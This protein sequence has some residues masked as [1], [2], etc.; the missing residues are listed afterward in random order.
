MLGRVESRRRIIEPAQH[1]ERDCDHDALVR[2]L[3]RGAVVVELQ[4]VEA[5]GQ[6][7]IATIRCRIAPFRRQRGG[8]REREALIS[9][10]DIKR[11]SEYPSTLILPSCSK[12]RWIP[13]MQTRL[14]K[15]ISS[16]SRPYSLR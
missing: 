4:L 6:L 13:S 9:G 10:S 5:A 12:C 14:S 8:D 11:W 1:D 15:L 2:L 16:I 7:L 3:D